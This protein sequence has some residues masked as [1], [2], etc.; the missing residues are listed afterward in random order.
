M[1]DRGEYFAPC[2]KY[3]CKFVIDVCRV[4]FRF[5]MLTVKLFLYIKMMLKVVYV[6]SVTVQKKDSKTFKNY[7]KCMKRQIHPRGPPSN[8]RQRRVLHTTERILDVLADR[9]PE[10]QIHSLILNALP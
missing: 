8:A 3:V 7:T 4:S 5:D 9:L 6:Y 10:N 2:Q 1:E